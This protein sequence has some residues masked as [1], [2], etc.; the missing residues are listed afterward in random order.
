[1]VM[2][3]TGFELREHRACFVDK[4]VQAECYFCAWFEGMWRENV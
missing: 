1:M 2:V 3:W 4:D